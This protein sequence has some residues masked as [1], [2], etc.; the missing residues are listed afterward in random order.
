MKEHEYQSEFQKYKSQLQ[1]PSLRKDL[2]GYLVGLFFVGLGITNTV[3][4]ESIFLTLIGVFVILIG[5]L[6]F[7]ITYTYKPEEPK[8]PNKPS[9]DDLYYSKKEHFDPLQ[10]EV[11]Q[12]KAKLKIHYNNQTIIVH[13]MVEIDNMDGFEFEKYIAELLKNLEF[14]RAIVTKKSGDFGAD[15]IVFDKNHEKVAVQC[16]RYGIKN[17]VGVDALQQI[18]SAMGYF[19][20]QKA[21]VIT[22]SNFSKPAYQ[23]AQ[24]LEVELWNRKTLKE[25]IASLKKENWNDY[26]DMFYLAPIR[27]VP[28]EDGKIMYV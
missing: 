21:M 11:N 10:S 1:R 4:S 16:K 28:L 7:F 2:L 24:K 5:F 15:I 13:E 12:Y 19:D 6:F 17:L 3:N 14:G 23:M 20:C 8:K 26:L 18:H 22:N 9:I 25:K 27:N